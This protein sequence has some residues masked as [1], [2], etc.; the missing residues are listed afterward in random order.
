MLGVHASP[1]FRLSLQR[2]CDKLRLPEPVIIDSGGVSNPVF[3]QAWQRYTKKQEGRS[4]N[5]TALHRDE[6]ESIS[7]EQGS[8]LKG[9]TKEYCPKSLPENQTQLHLSPSS[10]VLNSA[11]EFLLM[12]KGKRSPKAR[13][14]PIA[15]PSIPRF[16]NTNDSGSTAAGRPITRS[17]LASSIPASASAS[18][19]ASSSPNPSSILRRPRRRYKLTLSETNEKR[20]ARS[21]NELPEN[22]RQRAPPLPP[23]PPPL[24]PPPPPP[25]SE[26][27]DV[28]ADSSSV[29]PF[30]IS[31]NALL[32]IDDLTSIQADDSASSI[33]SRREELAQ[34]IAFVRRLF[35]EGLHHSRVHSLVCD[36]SFFPHAKSFLS[37]DLQSIRN[38]CDFYLVFASGEREFRSFLSSLAT[39][40]EYTKL[41]S[42]LEN[43]VLRTN[44]LA[45]F[46]DF[47]LAR[48]SLFITNNEETNA[49]LRVR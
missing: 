48:P 6:D 19:T 5:S 37:N 33:Q 42:L 17:S 2:M 16:M 28:A 39:K 23:L 26:K 24:P 21:E 38:N 7:K 35:Q 12:T 41:H 1:E 15:S 31:E 44:K 43:S 30:Q 14:N 36:Q 11:R 3:L 27:N 45:S 49:F 8:K 10:V 22:K 18:S 20:Q 9:K 25:P 4:R 34:R 13:S 47:R 32:V 46:S 29:T 40:T